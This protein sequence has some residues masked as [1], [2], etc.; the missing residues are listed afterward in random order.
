M[1]YLIL[2]SAVIL[3]G[4]QQ[5]VPAPEA[6]SASGP[7]P[8]KRAAINACLVEIGMAPLPETLGGINAAM[9]QAQGEAFQACMARQNS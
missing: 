3:A 5:T 9:N 4:C 2:L 1:R 8:E 7:T 6:M